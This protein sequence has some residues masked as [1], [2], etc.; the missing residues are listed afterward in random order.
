MVSVRR[1]PLPGPASPPISRIV[2]C[3]CC[4]VNGVMAGGLSIEGSE[5]G[6]RFKT[7][8]DMR[9]EVELETGANVVDVVVSSAGVTGAAAIN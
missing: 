1:P 2:I 6:V 5:T 4:S 3:L 9:G 7:G 8:K